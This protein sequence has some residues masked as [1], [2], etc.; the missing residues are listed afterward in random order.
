MR[1]AAGRREA[2]I[3]ESDEGHHEGCEVPFGNVYEWHPEHVAHER[4]C[5]EMLILTATSTMTACGRCG[6]DLRGPHQVILSEKGICRTCS[7]TLRSATLKSGPNNMRFLA[8]SET[9]IGP[10][11]RSL[12]T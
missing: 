11:V 3:T 1:R 5:G 2:V 9:C 6:A 12:R 10:K 4:G 7:P 8:M